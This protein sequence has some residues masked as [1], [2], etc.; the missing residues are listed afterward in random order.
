MPFRVFFISLQIIRRRKPEGRKRSDETASEISSIDSD[1]NFRSFQRKNRELQSS[2]LITESIPLDLPQRL[3]LLERAAFHRPLAQTQ[4]DDNRFLSCNCSGFGSNGKLHSYHEELRRAVENAKQL[5]LMEI[6]ASKR[7]S[8]DGGNDS[9]E[10]LK[11]YSMDDSSECRE[12]LR[13]QYNL[14]HL[15]KQELEIMCKTCKSQTEELMSEINEMKSKIENYED[16][17]RELECV[18]STVNVRNI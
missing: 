13:V 14:N 16:K 8:C 17:I 11:S 1:E 18:A 7:H 12:L 10:A 4:S 15:Y 2:M 3:H 9:S 6:K 5:L